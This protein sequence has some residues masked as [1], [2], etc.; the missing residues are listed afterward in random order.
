MTTGRE[1]LRAADIA[2]LTGVSLRTARRWIAKEI[3]AST[4]VGGARLVARRELERLLSP[5]R[6]LGKGEIDNDEDC[7]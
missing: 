2:Q 5:C 3:L 4:K 6:E 1:Y 7:Q